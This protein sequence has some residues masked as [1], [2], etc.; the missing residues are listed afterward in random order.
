MP[1][2]RLCQARWLIAAFL[3][4]GQHGQSFYHLAMYRALQSHHLTELSR[5]W[6]KMKPLVPLTLFQKAEEKMP[7][8]PSFP[9]R[10]PRGGN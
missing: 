10:I 6:I 5:N 1:Q 4:A 8:V 9:K 7:H 3:H 2:G